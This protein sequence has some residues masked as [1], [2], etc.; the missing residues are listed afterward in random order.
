MSVMDLG[1]L[2]AMSSTDVACGATRVEWRELSLYRK[3]AEQCVLHSWYPAPYGP[4]QCPV[5]TYH[6]LL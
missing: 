5:L 1:M 4:M 6:S 3:K 2:Q